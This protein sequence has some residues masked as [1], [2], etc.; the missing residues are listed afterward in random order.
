MPIMDA[1]RQG[2]TQ[3][4]VWTAKPSAFLVLAA[5]LA[6][7]LIFEPE[8]FDWHGFAT[9]ATWFMTL[10]IQRAEHR[11][12]QAVHGKL[13]ELLRAH[14]H[15]DTDMAQLDDEEPEDIERRRKSG[16][17]GSQEPRED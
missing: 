12:T 15:A 17:R 8:T 10:L 4:G 14:H 16:K 2:L 5:Y 7:W 1:I 9:M 13:D 6:G 11:D 3:L